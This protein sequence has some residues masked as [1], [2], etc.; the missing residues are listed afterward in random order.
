MILADPNTPIA[1]IVPNIS[2]NIPEG[3]LP[4]LLPSSCSISSLFS[5][6]KILFLNIWFSN[7][8]FSFSLSS[9]II[10]FLITSFSSRVFW[11][12]NFSFSFWAFNFVFSTFIFFGSKFIVSN[13][14]F[15]FLKSQFLHFFHCFFR[16]HLS[17]SQWSI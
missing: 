6:S 9:S 7:F 16:R 3:L 12:N 4:A 13:V 5:F 1:K 17:L 11:A 2:K 15:M 8:T 14:V 10:N